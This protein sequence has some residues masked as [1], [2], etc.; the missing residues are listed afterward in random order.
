[1][2]TLPVVEKILR[3][4]GEPMSVRQI[5]EYAKGTLPT[6]SK[7]PDTVVARDL[8]MDIKRK[9]EESQFARVAPGRYTMRALAEEVVGEPQAN[10]T[11]EAAT[12]H[13]PATPHESEQRPTDMLASAIKHERAGTLPSAT[14]GRANDQAE[15]SSTTH[16]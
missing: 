12:A 16:H 15:S 3:E 11:P 9:G 5:V 10:A 13:E 4:T 7:T 2:S 14:P 8:A 6:R 1:M